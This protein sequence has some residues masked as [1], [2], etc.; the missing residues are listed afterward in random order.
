VFRAPTFL[1][2][3]GEVGLPLLVMSLFPFRRDE[4]GLPLLFVLLF[5]FNVMRRVSPS[6]SCR[7]SHF[8]TMRRVSPS[9]LCHYSHFDVMRRVCPSSPCCYSHFDEE[10]VYP[11]SSY[12]YP[13][14]EA[15]GTIHCFNLYIKIFVYNNIQS[16]YSCLYP[17]V[18]ET[19]HPYPQ[20]PY[21]WTRVQV[22]MG[23]GMGSAGDTRGLPMPFTM[24]Q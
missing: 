20:N 19:C 11:S 6:S 22:S 9:S 14:F 2:C 8:N 18:V 23:T 15:V 24:C 5:R 21:L 7:Y 4:E 12:C 10:E 13:H 16:V 1:F 3:H 17:Q